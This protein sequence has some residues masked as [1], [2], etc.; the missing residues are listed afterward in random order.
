MGIQIRTYEDD[1]QPIEGDMHEL[2]VYEVLRETRKLSKPDFIDFFKLLFLK[3]NVQSK[4]AVAGYNTHFSSNFAGSSSIP[5]AIQ[6]RRLS[7][8]TAA[9]MSDDI[10]VTLIDMVSSVLSSTIR[11]IDRGNDDDEQHPTYD[12]PL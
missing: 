10:S 2:D 3:M 9:A 4:E 7:R 11:R 8:N 12:S 5:R 6:T 1:Q